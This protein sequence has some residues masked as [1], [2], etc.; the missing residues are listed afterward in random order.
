MLNLNQASIGARKI[1]NIKIIPVILLIDFL[2][3]RQTTDKLRNMNYCKYSI[4]GFKFICTYTL[5]R[6]SIWC[7][8]VIEKTRNYLYSFISLRLLQPEELSCVRKTIL[9][10]SILLPYAIIAVVIY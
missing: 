7:R 10:Y 2:F 3:H 9:Y 1:V 5:Y 8:T 6:A 4:I